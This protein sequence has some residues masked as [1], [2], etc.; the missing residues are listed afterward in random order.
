[1]GY[2]LDKSERSEDFDLS[3]WLK[4][5]DQWPIGNRLTI[6]QQAA[7]NRAKFLKSDNKTYILLTD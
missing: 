1:M 7:N 4:T 5:N 2:G 6:E 3:E